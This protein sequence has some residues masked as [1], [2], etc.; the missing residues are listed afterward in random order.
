MSNQTFH[1]P[2]VSCDHC[3]AA[4]E[5]EVGQL[6]AVEA[7]EVSVDDRTVRVTGDV[8]ANEVE[9]AISAA[10]YEVA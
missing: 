1:V 3:K 6:A 5:S 10:G 8:Q 4:I 9:Q 2:E 7:V